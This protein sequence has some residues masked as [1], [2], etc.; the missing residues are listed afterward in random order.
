MDLRQVIL[1]PVIIPLIGAFVVL[2]LRSWKSLQGRLA[3]LVMLISLG[4][5][6]WLFSKVWYSKDAVV[7]QL[8]GWVAPF[9]ITLVADPL[10][11]FMVIMSQLVLF[12][13]IVYSLGAKD[14]AIEYPTFYP[15]FLCLV[16]GL[17]G[18]FLSGDLFNLFVFAELLVI[19]GTVLTAIS[20]DL[21]GAEAAYKYFYISL[22]ASSFMLL[23]IGC[24]YVSYGSLNMADLAIRIVSNPVPPLLPVAI[25]FLTATFMVK[26]AVF[27]FHFWQPDFHAA[28]S[29]PVSAMLSSVVVKLG[30]YGFLRMTTLLFVEQSSQIQILLISLGIFSVF[31]G[32]LSAIGTHN[33]KRMLA[34]ST[35]AQIGFILVGIGWNTPLSIAAALVFAFNHS[36]IKAAMLMLTGSVAS[37]TS[38][39][40]AAFNILTGTGKYMAFAGILFFIGSLALAGIPPTNGFISKYLIFSSGA[41]L[42]EYLILIALAFGGILS[43]IYTLRAFEKIWWLP[44]LDNG[45]IKPEGDRL[46]APAILVAL[47]LVFGVWAEPLI[48]ISQAASTW[49]QDPMNYIQ[50]VMG[51]T[52]IVA[53]GG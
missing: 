43:I 47:I 15:L 14:K 49:L 44:K 51:S 2:L 21:Y 35:L 32:G 5:S 33:A 29:T 34:Y 39:K 30:I 36:L 27:P 16:V 20:D 13:G 18:A 26:S 19:S 17:T 22:L 31:F 7:Y 6:F 24:L 11:V 23:A 50:A 38:I 3:F 8:G 48:Q 40:S 37:R 45:A 41:A 1:L 4:C 28:A 25:A 53:F 52:I 9:G 10:S 46:I 42:H 12:M